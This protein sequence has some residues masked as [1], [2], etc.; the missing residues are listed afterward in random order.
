[1]LIRR[2]RFLIPAAILLFLAAL[3]ADAFW[4]GPDSFVI[5]HEELSPPRWNT[6]LRIAAVSDLHIGSRFVGLDKL[7]SIVGQINAE[8]PDMV[9]IMG[10][11]VIGGPRSGHAGPAFVTPEPPWN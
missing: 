2:K 8:H 5:R 7:R 1:M 11:F 4:L 10:D 9:V 6:N 3:A